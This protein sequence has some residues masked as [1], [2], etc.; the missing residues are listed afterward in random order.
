MY[1]RCPIAARAIP[2]RV[3]GTP[4]IVT[5]LN[6]ARDDRQLPHLGSRRRAYHTNDVAQLDVVA[7]ERER[8]G[9]VNADAVAMTCTLARSPTKSKN[10]S[11]DE[12]ARTP[13]TRP[14]TA[15]WVP[16]A[17]PPA[18]MLRYLSTKSGTDMLVAN[19]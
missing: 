9:S 3:W 6:A 11:L 4:A 16:S 5:H 7:C 15:S 14:A 1:H 13:I 2:P 8:L 12:A 10:T 18:G 17:F 19:L